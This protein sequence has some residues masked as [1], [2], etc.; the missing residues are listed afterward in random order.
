[1]DGGA[2]G[3]VAIAVVAGTVRGVIVDPVPGG[4]DRI[5]ARKR[6]QGVQRENGG[7]FGDGLE[8]SEVVS[9]T[10]ARG[11]IVAGFAQV[12]GSIPE[13]LSDGVGDL[14]L[15]YRRVGQPLGFNNQGRDCGQVGSGGRGA[16]EQIPRPVG[17]WS[18]KI[19]GTRHQYPI[20]SHHIGFVS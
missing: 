6:G 3:A 11:I 7:R 17:E 5:F 2:K 12:D 14:L 19:P 1:M 16:E 4:I 20:D 18:S 13:P 9:T 10:V 8:G 15:G